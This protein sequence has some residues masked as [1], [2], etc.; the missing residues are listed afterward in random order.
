[1]MLLSQMTAGKYTL[2]ISDIDWAEKEKKKH[3]FIFF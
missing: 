1:M 2:S 3:I